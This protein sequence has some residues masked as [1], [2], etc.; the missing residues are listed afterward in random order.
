LR[1]LASRFISSQQILILGLITTWGDYSE[2]SAIQSS[3]SLRALLIC[4][5]N[6][7]AQP[8]ASS[9][10][11]TPACTLSATSASSVRPLSRC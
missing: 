3:L 11:S 7:V 9:A 8:L 6:S 4:G 5:A 2:C 10:T 1:I